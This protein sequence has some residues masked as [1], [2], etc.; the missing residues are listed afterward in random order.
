MQSLT[1]KM[2][3][4]FTL[5]EIMMVVLIM[6]LLMAIALP[7]FARAR[8]HTKGK[9]CQHNLKQILGAKERWA[10]DNSRGPLDTPTMPELAVPGV[11]MKGTPVCPEGGVYTVGPMTAMPTCSIGGTPGEPDAHVTN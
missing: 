8:D 5:V 2:R 7:T 11:Y 6:G 3:R 4:G 9:A 1:K 10:M